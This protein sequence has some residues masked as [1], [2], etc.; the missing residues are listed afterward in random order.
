MRPG[1][2][3]TR[4]RPGAEAGAA[5]RAGAR[6][7]GAEIAQRPDAAAETGWPDHGDESAGIAY[8]CRRGWS[9]RAIA[10]AALGGGGEGEAP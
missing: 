10:I 7:R 4:L 3:R 8:H 5:E 6:R 9:E 2:F 1:R